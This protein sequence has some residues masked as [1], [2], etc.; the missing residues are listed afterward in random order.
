MVWFFQV[1]I[2]WPN[3]IGLGMGGIWLQPMTLT[4]MQP[5][6]FYTYSIKEKTS[7]LIV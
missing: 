4:T 1:L 2:S 5:I 6:T 7:I 3:L